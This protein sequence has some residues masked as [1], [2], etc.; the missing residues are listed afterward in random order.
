MINTIA[1]VS[2][3]VSKAEASQNLRFNSSLPISITVL[4]VMSRDRYKLLLGNREFTTRSLKKLDKNAKY[5]GNFGESKDGIITISGLLKKPSC[6]Q[7]NEEFFD[8]DVKEFLKEY[9]EFDYP[10]RNYK[11]WILSNLAM[12]DIDKTLF[13]TFTYMLL[14]QNES[15]IHL[16]FKSYKKPIL[17]Q[18]QASFDKTIE[19]YLAY[20]NL[21]PIKGVLKKE[22]DTISMEIKILFE[23]SFY[24][25]KRELNQLKI[26]INM[27][28][29]KNIQPLFDIDMLMLDIKG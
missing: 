27:K 1:N 28:I 24:F 2:S 4:E 12:R 9:K 17:V 7:G 14:A 15:V 10:S 26:D 25:L 29:D 16:P 3:V 5:W 20:E 6:L 22:N 21:G 8:I 18:F 11:N 19:F 23:K 13:Q